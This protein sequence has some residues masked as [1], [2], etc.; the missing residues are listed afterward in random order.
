MQTWWM[1]GGWEHRLAVRASRWLELS[2]WEVYAKMTMCQG[3][4]QDQPGRKWHRMRKSSRQ[5]V[6]GQGWRR[7]RGRKSKRNESRTEC[8]ITS[9]SP[10]PWSLQ[11][12][13]LSLRE[14]VVMPPGYAK[15]N[16]VCLWQSVGW[17]SL[18][19][20]NLMDESGPS[21]PLKIGIK[22]LGM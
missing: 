10:W 19:I 2:P 1:Y 5:L 17:M 16:G 13:Q 6:R 4:G 22:E 15:S 12:Q 9:L 8:S 3:S 14:W 21:R 11:R 20:Q 7:F 18:M